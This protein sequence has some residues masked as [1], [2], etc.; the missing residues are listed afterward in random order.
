MA[1]GLLDAY[2]GDTG[3][4]DWL[5]NQSGQN[6]SYR[7]NKSP[8][9]L[10]RAKKQY[11][12]ITGHKVQ[13]SSTST[14]NTTTK[15]APK[16]TSALVP[17]SQQG[18]GTGS[19]MAEFQAMKQKF[20]PSSNI[21]AEYFGDTPID[22][23]NNTFNA[24]SPGH[25]IPNP[26]NNSTGNG[27]GPTAATAEFYFGAPAA[28]SSTGSDIL[29]SGTALGD[30]NATPT[31]SPTPGLGTFDANKSIMGSGNPSSGIVLGSGN[32]VVDPLGYTGSGTY[33]PSTGTTSALKDVKTPAT[34][35]DLRQSQ[36]DLN[37]EYGNS[38]TPGWMDYSALGMQ[39]LNSLA[40]IGSYFNNRDLGRE[41]MRSL[42]QN[43][44]VAKTEHD[45]A[46]ATK[47][48]NNKVI[49]GI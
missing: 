49:T 44:E 20:N 3:F 18:A 15:V 46:M 23:L 36:I 7:V 29:S 13:A 2:R 32:G 34:E 35:A 33:D 48:H 37:K 5:S 21:A 38:L 26:I 42:K 12:Q 47:R 39:G 11:E 8:S 27:L 16:A 9:R 31:T 40:S 22:G 19:S 24:N 25:T 17:T 41:Q 4:M 45:Q 28:T 6:S 14:A 1:N 10:R 30:G 43:R